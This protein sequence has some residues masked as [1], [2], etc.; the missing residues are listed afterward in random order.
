LEKER[1]NH[2]QFQ[3]VIGHVKGK[4]IYEKLFK[5]FLLLYTLMK[6][7]RRLPPANFDVFTQLEIATRKMIAVKI[8][9]GDEWQHIA[10][11]INKRPSLIID[12][13]M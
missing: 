2:E 1:S 13:S 8:S 3:D 12:A 11:L 7:Q 4:I 10:K 5:D 9:D 6:I